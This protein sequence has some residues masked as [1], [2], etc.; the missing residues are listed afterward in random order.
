MKAEI[1]AWLADIKQ[2]ITEIHLFLPDKTDFNTFQRDLKT[3]RAIERN[4]EIIW[5]IVIKELD[6]LEKEVDELLNQ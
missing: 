5:A 3:K 6:K 1:K 2:A 4:I